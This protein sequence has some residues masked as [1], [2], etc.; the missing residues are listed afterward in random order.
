MGH[1]RKV[2]K[3]IDY[4]EPEEAKVGDFIAQSREMHEQAAVRRAA[5]ALREPKK[6][7]K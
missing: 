4:D 5:N 1:M 3:P 2:L 6:I 7:K